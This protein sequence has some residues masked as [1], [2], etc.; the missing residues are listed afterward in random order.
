MKQTY[1]ENDFDISE[2]IGTNTFERSV[3]LVVATI[4][5]LILRLHLFRPQLPESHATASL[6]R[7]YCSSGASDLKKQA[8]D[9]EPVATLLLPALAETPPVTSPKLKFNSSPGSRWLCA[10]I[11]VVLSVA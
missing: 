8:G 6:L 10:S 5:C 4:A 7:A 9:S 1:L 11:D 2:Y 3:T